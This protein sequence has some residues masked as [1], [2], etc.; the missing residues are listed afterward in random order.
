MDE[1]HA[2]DEVMVTSSN[3]QPTYEKIEWLYHRDPNAIAEFITVTTKSQRVLRLSPNHLIPFVPCSNIE[4]KNIG[5]NKL[6]DT[7]SFYARKLKVGHCVAALIDNEFVADQI[8]DIVRETKRGIFSPITNQ[9]T[10]V[11][12]DLYVSCYSSLENHMIQKTV[13]SVIITLRHLISKV[14]S[15]FGAGIDLPQEDS[16]IPLPLQMLLK[17]AQVVLPSNV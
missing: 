8:V 16:N 1:I 12:N 11:V 14:S 15:I 6:A 13:H 5:L 10:I 4:M 9:G 3:S 7:Q 17:I 2:G